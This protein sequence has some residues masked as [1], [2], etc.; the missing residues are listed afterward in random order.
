MK[1]LAVAVLPLLFSL[2][3]LTGFAICNNCE[4]NPTSSTYQSTIMQRPLSWNRRERDPGDGGGGGPRPVPAPPIFGSSSYSYAV[5]ILHLP[6]R[7][8]LDVDLTLLYSS[9]VWTRDMT[10]NAMTF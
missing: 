7:N 8:G 9:R 10:A 2:L 3:P 1:R 4:P 6:G 5:P